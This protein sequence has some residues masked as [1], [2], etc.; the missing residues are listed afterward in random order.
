M[1]FAL[2]TTCILAVVLAAARLVFR[3]VVVSGASMHPLL[4]QGEHVLFER[5]RRPRRGDVVLVELDGR[6]PPRQ[7]KLLAGLP[8]ERI[9]VMR[10]R[11]WID[12]R[13]VRF[14]QPMIG[15]MPGSW[16]LGPDECFL[17]SYNV[18]IGT[19]S[20]HFGPVPWRAIRGRAL[21]VSRSPNRR[22]WLSCV[23]L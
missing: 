9:A 12:N 17:L 18:A 11:L 6:A 13:E 22:R 23:P 4:A 10:D 7:I 15:S 5:L 21:V 8:G 1:W 14:R 20:R 19:D 16:Q 3:R 2:A